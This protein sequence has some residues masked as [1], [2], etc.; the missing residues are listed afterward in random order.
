MAMPNFK[1]AG[2]D[3]LIMS[4]EGEEWE[5][6]KTVLNAYHKLHISQ[7]LWLDAGDT[8][9]KAVCSD[10]R[11]INLGKAV[12]CRNFKNLM[13][14]LRSFKNDLCIKWDWECLLY[15]IFHQLLQLPF[16]ALQIA[17]KYSSELKSGKKKK[18]ALLNFT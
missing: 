4:L 18:L 11:E 15:N 8:E 9:M 13:V 16:Q 7:I 12:L 17:M 3:N 2:K 5:I 1:W 14:K 6:F 10:L